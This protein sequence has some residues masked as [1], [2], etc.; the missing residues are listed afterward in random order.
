MIE[1]LGS[2]LT[3]RGSYTLSQFNHEGDWIKIEGEACGKDDFP[4]YFFSYKISYKI[5]QID[6]FPSSFPKI[7]CISAHDFKSPDEFQHVTICLLKFQLKPRR[8]K[9]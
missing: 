7:C 1:S 2:M 3:S 6:G 5:D 9:D 4:F 8:K